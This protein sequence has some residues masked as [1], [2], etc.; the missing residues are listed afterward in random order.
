MG[1][2][3]RTKA[4]QPRRLW[5]LKRRVAV[6][7]PAAPGQ[8]KRKRQTYVL[9]AEGLTWEEAQVQRRAEKGLEIFPWTAPPEPEALPIAPEE[10][11]AP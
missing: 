8:G 4:D 9:V 3:K 6:A 7:V 1:E 2:H 5:C 10:A 11:P